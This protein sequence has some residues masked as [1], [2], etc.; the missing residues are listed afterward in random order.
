MDISPDFADLF[1]ILRKHEVR[2][3]IVGAYALIYYTEPR[4]TKDLD[5]WVDSE[6]GNAERVYN[7]LKEFGAPLRGVRPKDFSKSTQFYQI[8]VAPVR[9]D[10]ISGLKGLKFER[11][12]K[13]RKKSKYGR[14]PINVISLRDLI[15]SKEASGRDSD[16]RD[17]KKLKK[18]LN[19]RF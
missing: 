8:G 11:A 5:I 9:V 13:R 10:I 1:R 12:W 19:R 17:V 14:I 2:Y 7:A 6:Q 15:T 4:Y 18:I 16:M 3:L